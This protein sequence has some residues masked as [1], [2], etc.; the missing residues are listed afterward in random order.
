MKSK[1]IKT[2]IFNFEKH[3]E[4]DCYIFMELKVVKAKYERGCFSFKNGFCGK[5]RPS[6]VMKISSPKWPKIPY[7]NKNNNVL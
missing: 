6:H 3:T 1:W 4:F 2:D 5:K 7:Q